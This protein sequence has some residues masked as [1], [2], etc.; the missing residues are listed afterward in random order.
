[1]RLT[2]M[3]WHGVVLFAFRM[4]LLKEFQKAHESVRVKN[5]N[6]AWS[7]GQKQKEICPGNPMT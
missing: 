1:M 6:L 3:S 2:N 5:W 7:L 4:V